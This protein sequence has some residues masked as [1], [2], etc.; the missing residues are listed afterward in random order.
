MQKGI[1]MKSKEIVNWFILSS[2]LLAGAVSAQTADATAAGRLWGSSTR[3]TNTIIA[4]S[5]PP[6]PPPPQQKIFSYGGGVCGGYIFGPPWASINL[7]STDASGC[8]MLG[9]CNVWRNLNGQ[10]Y[11]GFSNSSG[12]GSGGKVYVYSGG[13]LVQHFDTASNCG[14]AGG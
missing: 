4:N 5:P 12:G 7:V 14:Y 1:Q 6:P 8:N 11:F 9:G 10:G 3:A 2:G 13:V